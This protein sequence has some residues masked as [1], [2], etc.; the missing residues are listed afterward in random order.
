MNLQEITKKEFLNKLKDPVHTYVLDIAK[1][2]RKSFS[3]KQGPTVRT[4]KYVHGGKYIIDI[5]WPRETLN[6]K[7]LPTYM[8]PAEKI[9]KR[10]NAIV[11]LHKQLKTKIQNDNVVAAISVDTIS[12]GLKYRFTVYTEE[13]PV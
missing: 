1:G 8:H 12:D 11:A 4:R 10:E 6:P 7:N 3:K 2:L 13:G 5:T 9:V